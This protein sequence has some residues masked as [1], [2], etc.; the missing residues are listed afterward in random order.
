MLKALINKHFPL[1][2]RTD[3]ERTE[4][5]IRIVLKHNG[6]DIEKTFRSC[7]AD[8][9]TQKGIFD[10]IHEQYGELLLST[11]YRDRE[12]SQK[13]MNEALVQL[14]LQCEIRYQTTPI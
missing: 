2:F 5:L 4:Q 11:L 6:T 7:R 14:M 13:V 12:L 9:N 3:R 8:A 1:A 10:L